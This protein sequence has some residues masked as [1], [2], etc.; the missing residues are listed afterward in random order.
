MF[1]K[2][3]AKKRLPKILGD[4]SRIK[5]GWKWAIMPFFICS[6]ILG[7]SDKQEILQQMFRKFEVSDRLPGIFRKLTL[8][9]PDWSK[10][11]TG[12]GR[13]EYEMEKRNLPWIKGLFLWTHL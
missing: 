8:G 4:L 9:A 5:I 7:E 12:Q 13:T 6:K 2:I 3:S 10:Y 1:S 11:Q